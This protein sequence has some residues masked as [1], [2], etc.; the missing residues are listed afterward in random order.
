MLVILLA[1]WS[2]LLVLR[3]NRR[4]EPVVPVRRIEPARPLRP[5]SDT[6]AAQFGARASRVPV[7]PEREAP[8]ATGSGVAG[9][10]VGAAG[11]AEPR[12]AGGEPEPAPGLLGPLPSVP[13]PRRAEEPAAAVDLTG[14]PEAA[15]L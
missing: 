6:A 13:Q 14:P 1:A 10:G 3:H 12:P 9:P 11:A 8:T 15:A 7:V 4:A 2:Y 5:R